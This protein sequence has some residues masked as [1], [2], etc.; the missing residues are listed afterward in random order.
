M[1]K[2]RVFRDQPKRRLIVS[3]EMQT[4]NAIDAAISTPIAGMLRARGNRSEFV[5]L[6]IEEKLAREIRQK[7]NI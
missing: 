3:V 2:N 4:V 1:S 7:L 5:R 6:A